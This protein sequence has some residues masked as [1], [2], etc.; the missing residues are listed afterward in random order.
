MGLVTGSHFPP[1]RLDVVK[2]LST[3]AASLELGCTDPDCLSAGCLGNRFEVIDRGVESDDTI[4]PPAFWDADYAAETLRLHIVHGKNDR[5][6][7]AE[8]YQYS[9]DLPA[10]T[11][12]SLLHVH[13]RAGHP[14]LT[15][16]SPDDDV[17]TRLFVSDAGRAFSNATFTQ[18]WGKQ[19]RAAAMSHG[20]PYFAPSKAHTIF[21]EGYTQAAAAD[22]ELWEGAAAIM[23]NTPRQWR[24]SYTPGRK[25]RLVAQAVLRHGEFVCPGVPSPL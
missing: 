21:V 5:R 1:I 24:D 2:H 3:P 14:T 15:L 8:R 12:T 7:C 20:L 16:T 10:G 6:Q 19:M 23:G 11:L 17:D 22:L 18:Y 9:I 13:I 4:A 25:R